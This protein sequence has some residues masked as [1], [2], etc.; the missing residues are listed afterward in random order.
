MKL[1][2][3]AV[4]LHVPHSSKVIPPQIHRSLVLP[5][6]ELKSE[7]LR[8]TDS[9]TDELFD[10]SS[11][12]K[13]VFPVSR[14]VVDPERFPDDTDEPMSEFGMGAVYTKSSKGQQVRSI[15]VGDRLQL[16]RKYYTPHHTKLTDAIH[17][18][19]TMYGHCLIIDCHSFPS[20][21][22]DYE[23]NRTNRP[24]ICLGTDEYHTPGWLEDLLVK[25]FDDNGFSVKTNYPYSGTMV[26]QRYYHTSRKVRSIMIEVNRSLYM[27]E[28][29]GK[30]NSGFKSIRSR[31]N[32]VLSSL[33]KQF[34]TEHS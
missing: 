30:R 22:F 9:Y 23:K 24:D 17:V 27:D 5:D 13:I 28:R 33:A 4:I 21:P 3:A 19:L 10:Y 12:V 7:L 8:L 32:I 34:I 20:V 15:T 18:A 29:T 16:I 14:L 11:A 1:E 25:L 6:D 2:P 31:L 26:P